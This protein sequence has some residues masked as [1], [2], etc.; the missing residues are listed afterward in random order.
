VGCGINYPEKAI[1]PFDYLEKYM[2]TF[3]SFLEH[4]HLVI[5]ALTLLVFCAGL[6]M[7]HQQISRHDS[8]AW[9]DY[10]PGGEQYMMLGNN[11][12]AKTANDVSMVTARAKIPATG[13]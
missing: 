12:I 1:V 13:V 2:K 10:A 9:L 3:D 5:S 4:A 11:A 6:A 7:S 8:Y